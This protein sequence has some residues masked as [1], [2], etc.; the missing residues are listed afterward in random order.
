MPPSATA[1]QP[2][3]VLVVD[4]EESIRYLLSLIHI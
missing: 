4:G 1:V 2:P 3:R